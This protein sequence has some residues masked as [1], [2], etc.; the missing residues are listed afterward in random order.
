MKIRILHR[1]KRNFWGIFNAVD[2]SL[3]GRMHIK[4]VL[5]NILDVDFT[6]YINYA[7][8]LQI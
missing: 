3:I 1:K 7:G 6:H 4:Q 5:C 2:G 8:I